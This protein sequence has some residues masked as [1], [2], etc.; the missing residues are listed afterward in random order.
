[1]LSCNNCT[2]LIT[3]IG[4]FIKVEKKIND[5]V[6]NKIFLLR[7]NIY[8]PLCDSPSVPS[9]ECNNTVSLSDKNVKVQA[10]CCDGSMKTVVSLGIN[11]KYQYNGDTF[12]FDTLEELC[13][14]IGLLR[15]APCDAPSLQCLANISALTM[16]GGDIVMS[17]VGTTVNGFLV[18][19]I[20]GTVFPAFPNPNGDLPPIDFIQVL[21]TND[22]IISVSRSE[23]DGGA[24]CATSSFTTFAD[25][26]SIPV[27][28]ADTVL[29]ANLLFALP[30]CT[31]TVTFV[32]LNQANITGVTI[33]ATGEITIPAQLTTSES[34]YYAYVK[35]DNTVV[36]TIAIMLRNLSNRISGKPYA[37]NLGG[38]AARNIG[39]GVPNNAKK[40]VNDLP[41]QIG[42]DG[43]TITHI[44][45]YFERPLGSNTWTPKALPYNTIIYTI[46]MSNPPNVAAWIQGA[47]S[48]V[49]TVNMKVYDDGIGG[50]L[51]VDADNNLTEA[52]FNI[53]EDV[54]DSLGNA[55]STVAWSIG[56]MQFGGVGDAQPA[57]VYDNVPFEE[58]SITRPMNDVKIIGTSGVLID[59]PNGKSIKWQSQI[60]CGGFSNSPT[61]IVIGAG[62]IQ[63]NELGK[64][65]GAMPTDAYITVYDANTSAVV[66]P[67]TVLPFSSGGTIGTTAIA[68]GVYAMDILVYTSYGTK[69]RFEKIFSVNSG[70]INSSTNYN[71]SPLA[72]AGNFQDIE[73]QH[74]G[75]ALYVNN[76]VLLNYLSIDGNIMFG[77]FVDRKDDG[78]VSTN[79]AP[80]DGSIVTLSNVQ[81]LS[82]AKHE[83]AAYWTQDATPTTALAYKKIQ[84]IVQ[85][86]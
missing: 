9:V 5:R 76:P 29:D 63:Y 58:A 59:C 57:M 12:T 11:C 16:A 64:L 28:G 67:T 53:T 1:M 52:Y 26:T 7:N 51:M 27:T 80:L 42:I 13:Q 77:D 85:P 17:T 25:T 3:I 55:V 79:T 15:C 36:A 72:V 82:E 37:N 50:I 2:V 39:G 46:P 34:Y 38:K 69:T 41:M 71:F 70:V 60:G 20:A 19:D 62:V 31:G 78:T 54:T 73:F 23:T 18:I 43:G 74:T 33:L 86:L 44:L 24:F 6:V 65:G 84:F 61:G 81:S 48:A 66:I 4:W 22:N 8:L 49:S 40:Y 35:C 10:V 32:E 14:W 21:R 75:T 56:T 45:S 47:I 83:L 68:D 30:A